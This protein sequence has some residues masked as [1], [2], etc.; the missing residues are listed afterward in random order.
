MQLNRGP[1]IALVATALI[2]IWMMSS[3]LTPTTIEQPKAPV[4]PN[5]ES[6]FSVQ[7]E[8]F[9][10][11]TIVP[12]LNIYGQ[13]KPN[14]IVHLTGEIEGKV[15][16]ILAREGSFVKKGQLI[17]EIDPQDKPQKLKQARS[18]VKQREL[19]YKANEKLIDQGLQNQTRLAESEALLESA[20]AQVKA[21]EVALEATNIR[22]PFDG[23]LE[24]RNVEL[25]SFV[26]KGNK[27]ITLMDF[28]PFLISGYVAEK[29]LPKVKVGQKAR[30]KTLDGKLHTG[31]IRYVSSQ[32][33]QS[34]RTFL[35]ELEISNPSER[36][37]NGVTAEILVPLKKSNAILVSPALLALNEKGILG[38]KHVDQDNHVIFS[39]VELIK[40]QSN[41]VWISGLPNP[42]DL[43]ITGQSFVSAGE[44]VTPVLKKKAVKADL[45]EANTS[46]ADMT[47]EAP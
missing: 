20:K 33:Y 13:T 31:I 45:L 19:E 44:K 18:L 46:N 3:V 22:A 14:R 29:D 34:S 41:G 25:G 11:Q 10:S 6:Y 27:I 40:A 15:T 8:R 43:I 16:K 1:I 38:A 24:N 12:E 30:G 4:A 42:V 36:Q 26:R 17:L 28:N 23:V 9:E 32:A 37:I 5:S 39:P 35:V 2:I 21:L 47:A 7:V